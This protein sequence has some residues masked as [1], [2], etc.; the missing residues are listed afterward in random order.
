MD[1]FS[2]LFVLLISVPIFYIWGLISFLR[3]ITKGSHKETPNRRSYLIEAIKDLQKT[4]ATNPDK[5]ITDLLSEYQKELQELPTETDISEETSPAPVQEQEKHM[6]IS[7]QPAHTEAS[8]QNWYKDNSINL[9]LYI[10]AFLIVVSATIFVSLPNTSGISKSMVLSLL[11]IVFFGS[12]LW[13][14]TLPRIKN[15]GA[16]FT[17]IGALLIPVTGLGWY[18]FVFKYSD[19]S[20]GLVWL[21]TSLVG[22]YAYIILARYFK[23]VFYSYVTSFSALSFFLAFINMQSLQNDFYVLGAILSSIILLSV[24]I[25]LREN[26]KEETIFFEPFAITANITIPIAIVYGLYIISQTPHFSLESTASVFLGCTFYILSY[27]YFKKS[28]YIF[29]A[30]ILFTLGLIYFGFWQNLTT[31]TILYLLM[32][33]LCVNLSLV[34]Y[35]HKRTQENQAAFSALFTMVKSTIIFLFAQSTNVAPVHLLIFT[36][37]AMRR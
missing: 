37:I 4:T 9:L 21:V 35:F 17:A 13:F 16:A 11:M 18:N 6:T 30:Q 1:P 32:A 33:S 34:A 22:C 27:R 24:S 5:K 36:L 26:K 12:G 23:S 7:P 10:G 31:L 29:A 20:F 8:I 15:A 25:Y 3:L 19:V 14:H 28:E 2:L